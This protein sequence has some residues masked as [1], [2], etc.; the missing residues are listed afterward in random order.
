MHSRQGAQVLMGVFASILVAGAAGA[1][2]LTRGP[3]LQ[4]VTPTSATVAFRLDTACPAQVRYGEGGNLSSTA[5]SGSTARQHGIH[6]TGLRPGTEYSYEVVGCGVPMGR[7]GRLRT[8]PAPQSREVRFGVLGDFGTGSSD[9]MDVARSIQAR[10]P[11]LIV[12]VGDNIYDS[13]TDAEFESNFLRPMGSLLAEVPL[14]ASLGNHEYVTNQGQPYLDNFYLPSN[15]PK[16]TERYYSFDW[17]NVHFVA[18]DSSCLLEITSADRCTVVE[19]LDW[20][21]KDLATSKAQWKIAYFHYPL[22]SSGKY[23]SVTSLRK[24]LAPILEAGGVDLVFTGH[25]HDYERTRPMKGDAE[26]APGDEGITYLVVGSGGA[27]LRPFT[28]AQPKWSV[29]RDAENNGFLEVTVQRERLTAQMV[30]PSGQVIDSFSLTQPVSSDAALEL[31]AQ[32]EPAR[33]VAPL[34]VLLAATVD[35][36][37]AQVSW[38]LA[39]G[40]V[41]AGTQVRERFATP[42]EHSVEVEARRGEQVATQS[43]VVTVSPSGGPDEEESPTTPPP[44]ER[45]GTEPSVPARPEQPFS[46][47]DSAGCN[48]GGS[49]LLL[50]ALGGLGVLLRG[51]TRRRR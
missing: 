21:E 37:D 50:G 22:W 18:L 36:P 24:R 49:S 19:Q 47:D 41:L 45:P 5:G 25:E 42:G 15:N 20:L 33:G 48:V 30:T 38:R 12:S 11:E 35:P 27:S 2:S 14:F 29:I 4:S 46:P 16:G 26:A 44:S 31:N 28:R 9:Q 1:A 34:E 40:R 32:A 6:L 51:R 3:Y 8:A 23:G 10:R 39:D 43:L 17:G 13:G 7:A